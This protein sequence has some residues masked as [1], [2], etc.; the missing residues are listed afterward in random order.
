[1]AQYGALGFAQRGS[2]Y[3]RILAHYYPGTELGLAPVTTVRVLVA[4]GRRQISI[5]S[6]VPFTLKTTTGSR[7]LEPG[8]YAVPGI[9]DVKLPI[10]FAPGRAPLVVDGKPYRGSIRITQTG[11]KVQA[12]NTLG[13]DAY[14]YGVIA[15]EMQSSWPAEALK[16]QAVAA[17]SY[18]MAERRGGEFDVYADTRS[19]VYG[20]IAAETPSARA[21]VDGTRRRVLFYDGKVAQTFFSASSGGRTADVTDIWLDSKPVPYLVSVPDPYDTVSPYHD[22]GPVTVTA[23]RAARLLALPGLRGVTVRRAVSQ[24]VR[25]VL[26]GTPS[27]RVAVAGNVFRRALELRSTWFRVGVLQLDRVAGPVAAG[28]E[29]RLTGKVLGLARPVLEQRPAGGDWEA[30]ASLRLGRSGEFVAV[31]RPE[32]TTD[33]RLRNG[34]ATG[35][36]V[37]VTVTG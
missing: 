27:G 17:R 18:A 2:T 34:T 25:E 26:V 6:E 3:D 30:A 28:A 9:A 7:T 22:W 8:T 36:A 4:E 1:M 23:A 10:V 16:T 24:R 12:V 5:G 11:S 20:G 19:Q 14:L 29:V 15:S 21:A 13:L 33:Y 35:E 31:A 32:A 37:R